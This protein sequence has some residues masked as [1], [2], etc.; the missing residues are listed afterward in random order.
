MINLTAVTIGTL[1][2]IHATPGNGLFDPVAL[3]LRQ[4]DTLL[5]NSSDTSM[6]LHSIM[7]LGEP[8]QFQLR[9]SEPRYL[10]ATLR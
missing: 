10:S 1:I 2:A 6:L 4:R 8:R 7:D 9:F 3:R 5:R